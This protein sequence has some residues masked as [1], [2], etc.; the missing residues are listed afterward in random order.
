MRLTA[1]VPVRR[2]RWFCRSTPLTVSLVAVE[3]FIDD[4]DFYMRYRD[5][6]SMVWSGGRWASRIGLGE[7]EDGATC[8]GPYIL[9]LEYHQREPWPDPP[10]ELVSGRILSGNDWQVFRDRM[11]AAVVPRSGA[12]GVALHFY[13]EDYFIYYD[14]TGVFHADRLFDKPVNYSVGER[15]SF[16]DFVRR[17]VPVLEAFLAEKGIDDRRIVF[18]T[19]DVGA[20]SSVRSASCINSGRRFA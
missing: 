3:A 8:G 20:Y 11:V 15:Q 6:N 13:V 9:P 5:A 7:L 1:S 16:L 12:V 2:D 4:T 19:G 18:N 17:G 14:Q 10:T